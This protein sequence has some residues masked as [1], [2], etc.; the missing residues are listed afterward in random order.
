M[1]IPAKCLDHIIS[2]FE[3]A[4]KPQDKLQSSSNS[5]HISL[6]DISIHKCSESYLRSIH[7]HNNI[8]RKCIWT[9]ITE[10]NLVKVSNYF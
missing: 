8:L 3:G 4:N 7:K 6:R 9:G 5:Y 2:C 10:L 1:N